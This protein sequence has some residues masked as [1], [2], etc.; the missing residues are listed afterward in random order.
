MGEQYA[1]TSGNVLQILLLSVLFASANT[2]SGGIVYGM[3]KHKRIAYWAIGEAIANFVLSIVLVRRIGI[4]GVAW[5]TTIPS[6]IIELLLW[7]RF[8]CKLVEIPVRTYL[9]QTWFR[10]ALGAL[11]FAIACVLA[12]RYWP[13]RNLVYFFL[14][15]AA[16]LPLFP[17]TLALIFQREVSGKVREWRKR[18]N[19][20]A[21]LKNE[22][23][24][25]TTTVG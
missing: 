7:P 23:E 15:I 14:Q 25:S 11:P 9:W 24:P 1:Q 17:L 8:I 16:L 19:A 22:Y 20:P 21:P 12:E 5:G 3:E 6:V 10:T 18:R 13:A 2:T 4:Y